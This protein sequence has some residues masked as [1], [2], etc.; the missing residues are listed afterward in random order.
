LDQANYSN[1]QLSF[2]LENPKEMWQ[3]KESK[4]T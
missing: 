3:V 4:S 1:S 2:L